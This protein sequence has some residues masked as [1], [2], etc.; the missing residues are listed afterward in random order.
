MKKWT[1][2]AIQKSIDE[3]IE[4]SYLMT[5][6]EEGIREHLRYFIMACELFIKDKLDSRN[7]IRLT[8]VKITL[9][10]SYLYLNRKIGVVDPKGR[11]AASESRNL[12]M[13]AQ[14]VIRI[15]STTIRLL[16]TIDKSLVPSILEIEKTLR[17]KKDYTEKPKLAKRLLSESFY[18]L[19]LFF[20]LS[21]LV[22]TIGS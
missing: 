10:R 18:F 17:E 9:L 19:L 2:V 1:D 11:A 5:L 20:V 14:N 4:E 3:L 15:K 21:L 13:F 6:T 22:A 12:D 8:K 7:D 16:D